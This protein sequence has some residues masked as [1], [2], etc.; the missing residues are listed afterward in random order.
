MCDPL[1]FVWTERSVDLLA[2]SFALSA[3]PVPEGNGETPVPIVAGQF[4]GRS[5]ALPCCER[6]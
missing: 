5:G 2:L 3:R 4:A 1:S 6:R